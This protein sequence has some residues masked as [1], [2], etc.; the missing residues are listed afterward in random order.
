[1]AEH[2]LHSTVVTLP[3]APHGVYHQPCAAKM[4]A[5]FVDNPQR[6]DTSCV[7]SIQPPVYTIGPPP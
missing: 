5:A 7:A 6:P 2:L 3:G 4:I 1:V